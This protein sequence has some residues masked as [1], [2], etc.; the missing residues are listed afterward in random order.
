MR[1]QGELILLFARDAVFFGDVLA[2][3]SHV[4]V[5]VDVPE[6]VVHHG[7]DDLG[8]AEA[9]SLARLRQKIG[10]VGHGFHAAGDDNGTVSGLHRLRCERDRFQSGAA[11]LVDCHGT[12]RRRQSAVDC[13][14]PRGIL[15]ES[16]GDDVAHD[17]FVDLRRIDAGTSDSLADSDGAKLRSAEVGEA[18]LKFSDGGAAAGNDDYIVKRGHE[19]SSR[20]DFATS[21]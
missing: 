5:V 18:A 19:S 10:S 4:V 9:V 3:D 21:L 12:C 15:T 6:S 7:V 1:V 17:A 2:G 20:E 16:S 14:L 11:N 8:V 13:G